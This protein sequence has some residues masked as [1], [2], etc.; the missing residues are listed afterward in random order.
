MAC[1]WALCLW[2]PPGYGRRYPTDGLRPHACFLTDVNLLPTISV[3]C[4]NC[5]AVVQLVGMTRIGQACPV[6]TS[7]M[8]RSVDIESVDLSTET[9]NLVSGASAREFCIL[10]LAANETEVLLATCFPHSEPMLVEKLRFVFG[11]R[12][13]L[14][15]SERGK[16]LDVIDRYLPDKSEPEICIV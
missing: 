4:C 3:Q 7:I 12:I 9:V 14:Y 16:L 10:P 8:G 1:S 15:Y 11:K 5:D 13:S 2:R 6:C